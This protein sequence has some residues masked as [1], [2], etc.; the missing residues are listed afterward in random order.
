MRLCL[1]MRRVTVRSILFVCGAI[2][3]IACRISGANGQAQP[4]IVVILSDDAGYGDFGFTG[5][6]LIATPNID[7]I[8]REGAT[9]SQFYTTASV[10]SP[11]RAGFI[12]GRYQQRFGHHSNLTGWAS[13]EGLGLDT[14]ECTVADHLRAR[15]YRTGIVGKWHLGSRSGLT[16]VER[17]FDEFHGIIAGSRTYFSIEQNDPKQNLQNTNLAANGVIE[18]ERIREADLNGFYLTDWIGDQAANFIQRHT[19]SDRPYY[20]FVSFTAPHTPME[21]TEHDLAEAGDIAPE[22]R[23][24]YAALMVALDRAVG[25]VLAAVDRSGS[26]DRTVVMF[27][28]DNGGATN[29]G[30][31]NGRYRG[32]KGSKW[33]GGI[34][35]PAA[36]KWP[37]VI[38]P[39]I[40][41]TPITSSMDL[42]STVINAAGGGID[43][44]PPLDGR[45][46]VPVMTMPGPWPDDAVH[47]A[48]FWER[49]PAAA[50]RSGPWKLVMVDQSDPM[51]FH[52]P[53]DPSETTDL[54]AE[55]PEVVHRLLEEYRVWHE[56][57]IEPLWLEGER[58]E[59]FQ[60]RKHRMD[61]LGRDAERGLP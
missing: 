51:L 37:G 8:A 25:D 14:A 4:N 54:S 13:D 56:M 46:L 10:C 9:L 41:F 2:L 38:E 43:G 27:F 53:A 42:T 16:P 45:D 7:R 21:A 40:I 11:S 22:L 3:L 52:I 5:G 35:V 36:I 19:Q 15:G 61:V 60:R 50:V 23:R 59:T 47:R 28:N 30:S 17:G 44:S 39:G 33:E 20:L 18:S 1:G 26:A 6:Q 24:Q 58:W 12:T 34:R 31:D 57:T 48:L 32:M 29:N 55:H 49:G